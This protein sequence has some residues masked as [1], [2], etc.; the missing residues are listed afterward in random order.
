MKNKLFAAALTAAAMTVFSAAA[1][2]EADV[3]KDG[4]YIAETALWNEVSDQ[5]SMGNKAFTDNP[6]SI[7]TTQNGISTIKIRT[8]PVVIGTITSALE[9]MIFKNEDNQWQYVKPLETAQ[10]TA[11]DGTNEH[12]LIY[13]KEFEL[14]IPDTDE[15][16]IPVKI[17]VPYTPMD[18][19]YDDGLI[20]ARLKIDW[21]TLTEY[22]DSISINSAVNEDENVRLNI[23]NNGLDTESDVIAAH[24]DGE[25][26]LLAANIK[27]ETIKSSTN[28]I[29]LENA[30]NTDAANS[31]IMIF[32]DLNGI[33]PKSEFGLIS[34]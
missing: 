13:I 7:I 1:Y 17:K 28:D 20:P 26:R 3:T 21:S 23:T 29:I 11:N 9:N 32:G 31:K 14:Q 34:K 5:P 12:E 16:Y 6:K 4:V 27:S 2:A 33:K 18:L 24:Y 10:I 15:T 19:I 22:D 25:G 30:S 8:N